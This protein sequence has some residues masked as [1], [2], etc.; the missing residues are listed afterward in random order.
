[1]ASICLVE[2]EEKVAAFI[3]KGLQ[4]QGYS[5][6]IARSSGEALS[7]LKENPFNLLILDVMLPDFDGINLCRIIRQDDS[8]IPVLMLTAL[9][10]TAEKV[11]GFRAGADDYLVKPFHFDE[12]IAR[13]EALLRR[14]ATDS[15]EDRYLRFDELT[16][17]LWT[18]AAFRGDQQISLTAR[19]YALLELFLRNPRKLLSR[20]YI[21]E[22]VWGIGFDTGT[23]VIDVYVN[24]LRNKVDKNFPKRLIHTMI[25]MGYILKSDED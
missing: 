13:I 2:D 12:L 1:M 6:A 19:E 23:N 5:V 24:Y 16:L 18:K 22:K 10:T 15:E 7:L 21:A 9:G 4:E 25:G 8:N 17:D 20:Q 3:K 11:A 14:T